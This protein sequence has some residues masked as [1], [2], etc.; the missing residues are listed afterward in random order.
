MNKNKILI[1]PAASYKK[2]LEDIFPDEFMM[3]MFGEMNII[4]NIKGLPLIH[5]EHIYITINKQIDEIYNISGLLN[6]QL[7]QL[8]IDGV[9]DVIII[10]ETKSVVETILETLK[11]I[12][13]NKNCGVF[14]KDADGYFQINELND[15]NTV[16][17]YLLEDIAE[18]NPSSKSYVSTT[19]DD[20]ILNIIE[21]RV[22]SSEFCAGGY[23][24]D[25]IEHMWK[26]FSDIADEYDKLY[27]SNAIYYDILKN[28]ETYRSEQVIS[29]NENI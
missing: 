11:R 24:F 10:D 28:D 2:A 13:Y 15:E 26:L 12:N 16:Y 21:K 14:I 4:Y 9:T 1:V 8:G 17:T 7:K 3:N 29:F 6:V 27:L 22:I 5:F 18:I 25:D 23:Y 19:S 20:I